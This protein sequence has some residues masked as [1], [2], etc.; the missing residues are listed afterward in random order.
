MAREIRFSTESIQGRRPQNED[1]VLAETLRK[2][3]LLLAVADGMGGHAAGEVASALALDTLLRA[4]REGEGLEHAVRLANREVHRA[5]QDPDKLG[6]GTTLTAILLQNDRILLANVGDSRAYYISRS[7]IRQLTEDHSFLAEAR[8]QGQ[9]REDAMATPWKDALTRSIGPDEEVEVDVF[10]PFPVEEDTALLLCSDGLYKTLRREG[11]RQVFLA[12]RDHSE[13]ATA[14]VWA[15]YEGGSDDNITVAIAEFG[16]FPRR[17]AGSRSWPGLE[18]QEEEDRGERMAAD[19]RREEPEPKRAEAPSEKDAVILGGEEET[20]W[21]VWEEEPVV[22]G[23]EEE[24]VEAAPEVRESPGVES[25]ATPSEAPLRSHRQVVG[26]WDL[27]R[28]RHP[29]LVGGT[30]PRGRL[31]RN[32]LFAV[33]A[34]VIV[35]VAAFLYFT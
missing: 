7:E 27:D 4:I 8:K 25:A 34:V 2:G 32:L 1:S 3:G 6:M 9:S 18:A 28:K 12:S 26:P 13:A 5:A 31:W 29:T 23:K 24:R 33:A 22:L 15:A 20:T 17:A 10:G 14:L 16:E 11:I 21:A 30:P 19:V 35:A